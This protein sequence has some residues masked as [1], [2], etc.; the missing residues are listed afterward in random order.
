MSKKCLAHL[1]RPCLGLPLGR[2]DLPVGE[3]IRKLGLLIL[4]IQSLGEGTD[5]RCHQ[6]EEHAVRLPAE[7]QAIRDQLAQVTAEPLAAIAV[8]VAEQ[9]DL[10]VVVVR[11]LGIVSFRMSGGV[12]DQSVLQVNKNGAGDLGGRVARQLRVAGAVGGGAG[13]PVQAVLLYIVLVDA[14]L[15]ERRRRDQEHLGAVRRDVG[16]RD[17]G[18]EV[19]LVLVWRAELRRPR[20]GVAGVVGAEEDELGMWYEYCE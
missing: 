14:R 3:R 20:P 4:L 2:Q 19:R 6:I 1:L 7:M 15:V 9:R 12:L 5:M 10:A 11:V 16:V 18:L 8:Q 13:Q 17:D